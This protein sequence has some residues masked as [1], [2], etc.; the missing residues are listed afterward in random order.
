MKLPSITV[1]VILLVALPLNAQNKRA[2]TFQ[3]KTGVL[4]INI[5]GKRFADYHFRTPGET[6][7]F[8]AN[9]YAPGQIK[10]TRNYPPRKN[11]LKDHP[12][13]QGIFLTFGDLNGIDFWHRKGKVAH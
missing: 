4:H 8:F 5:G 1:L 6:R 10:A 12:H 3:Q 9:V 7:P 13:H 11:D 2:V